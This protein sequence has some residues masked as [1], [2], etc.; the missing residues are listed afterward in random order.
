MVSQSNHHLMP[1]I[2]QHS[3]AVCHASKPPLK[4]LYIIYLHALAT[5]N[6][7]TCVYELA[8]QIALETL[9][10]PPLQFLPIKVK[11]HKKYL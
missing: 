11:M 4:Q 8:Y 5:I 3:S 7:A 6:L 1:A 10:V 2:P 9:L